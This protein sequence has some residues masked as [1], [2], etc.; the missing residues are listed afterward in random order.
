MIAKGPLRG[1]VFGFQF[2][3]FRLRPVYTARKPLTDVSA[4][5]LAEAENRQPIT[6]NLNYR[7]LWRDS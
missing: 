2:L 7:A 5:A 6:G 1:Q 4:I 3:V